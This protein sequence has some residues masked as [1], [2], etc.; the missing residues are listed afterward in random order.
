MSIQVSLTLDPKILL[1][2]LVH[3]P[4][5]GVHQSL[6]SPWTPPVSCPLTDSAERQVAF[7]DLPLQI[8][9]DALLSLELTSMESG[10]RAQP[11]FLVK[12]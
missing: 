1:M 5:P 11:I 7:P 12:S 3:L 10:H 4:G 8:S 6:H 2:V 9:P